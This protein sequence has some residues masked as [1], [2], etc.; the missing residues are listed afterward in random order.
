MKE[1]LIKEEV[2][3]RTAKEKNSIKIKRIVALI[4]SFFILILGWLMIAAGS[5]FEAQM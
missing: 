3:K 2:N 1:D 5:I 4:I